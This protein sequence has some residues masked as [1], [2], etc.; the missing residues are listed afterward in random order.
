MG[1]YI[2]NSTNS[3]STKKL[4]KKYSKEVHVSNPF[5]RGVFTITNYRKYQFKEEVEVQFKGEIHVMWKHKKDWYDSSLLKKTDRGSRVSLIKVNRFLRKNLMFS[6]K[7]H[8]RYFSVDLFHY[9]D[10]Q[11]IKWL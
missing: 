8:L 11:K 2:I 9:S 1:R 6:L 10:I 4:L 3:F 5:L 7:T